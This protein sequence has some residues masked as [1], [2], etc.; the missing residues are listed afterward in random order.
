MTSIF[1]PSR[2]TFALGDDRAFKLSNDFSAFLVCAVPSA[3]FKIRTTRITSV[4][5]R[6][7]ESADIAAAISKMI[8][9]TSKNC[10]AKIRQIGF[11]SSSS[12]SF[13]P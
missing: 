3:A 7:P 4:L 2:K 10:S 9:N 8:T 12:S 1:S 13:L 6:F 5:S 11:L